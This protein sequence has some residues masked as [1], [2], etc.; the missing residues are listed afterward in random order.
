MAKQ[1]KKTTKLL[2]AFDQ[3]FGSEG[4]IE[5]LPIIKFAEEWCGQRMLIWQRVVLKLY[6]GE[7]LKEIPD[8]GYE[9][10]EQE[11]FDRMLDQG[12][13]PSDT[14]E[15]LNREGFKGFK[16][17]LLV[18]GR[19]GGKSTVIAVAALYSAYKVLLHDNPQ[20]YYKMQENDTI[21]IAVAATSAAQS[22]RSPFKKIIAICQKAI[23]KNLPLADWIDEDGLKQ[24]TIYFKTVHDRM[25][26]RELARKGVKN[27]R[28][29]TVQINAYHANVDTLRGGA[30]LAAIF[31]EF[32]QFPVTQKGLDSAEY[33]YNSLVPST[34]QFG[35]DGRTFIIS[36]PQGELGKFYDIYLETW[37]GTRAST[38]GIQMPSW[39]AWEYEPL[40]TRKFGITREL[41]SESEDVHFTW[42]PNIETFE[43]AWMRTPSAVKME[44]GAEFIGA[45]E[46]WLSPIL[47]VNPEPGKGFRNPNLQH[48]T[49]GV[50][51]RMYTLHCDAATKTDA[52]AIALVHREEDKENGDQIIV[53]HAVRW[54][55][56]PDLYYTDRDYEFVVRQ[57]GPEPPQIYFKQIEQYIKEF[58]LGRFNVALIS[59][60][61][62]NSHQMAE[63]LQEYIWQKQM[64]TMVKVIPFTQPFNR[65]RNAFF[66][67]MILENRIH[68]YSHPILEEE[69]RGLQKDRFGKVEKGPLTTDDLY[70]AVSTAAL[71]AMD[72]PTDYDT[73]FRNHTFN[74]D[75]SIA[76]IRM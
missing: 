8:P 15:R 7:K 62:H 38:I 71:H 12:R 53:D 40:E 54:Y 24:Q 9:I 14:K 13:M 31:D 1:K 43:D 70:D 42:D 17:I 32:A 51:G 19:R 57:S 44:F 49:Q 65:K 63:R 3:H 56:A 5:L 67:T 50:I 21:Q 36:T 69:L 47:I 39:E 11:W 41:M 4:Q 25:V 37:R 26:Q 60:D 64:H 33:F 76:Q 66:E 6:A 73:G 34:V 23:S 52:F 61:Q 30:V 28:V 46:Q 74:M 16:S 20:A 58:I 29:A 10:S 18:V 27:Q 72:L 55:V 45:Q 22:Q 59:F 2:R 48:M 75:P 68:S 35:D